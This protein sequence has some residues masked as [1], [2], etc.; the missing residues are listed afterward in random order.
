MLIALVVLVFFLIVLA[1]SS[2]RIVRPYERGL[3]KGS[4]SSKEK[5]GLEYIS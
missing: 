2:I 4:G 1:A 3:W 5:S